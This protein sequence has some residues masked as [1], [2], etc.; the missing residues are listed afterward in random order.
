MNE[1]LC[2]S[3]SIPH[4][5]AF[6]AR[7][8]V[9]QNILVMQPRRLA[10]Q[11]LSK[12][13]SDLT[14]SAF[15]DIVGYR[16]SMESAVSQ[17]TRI[18]FATARFALQVLL[19]IFLTFFHIHYSRAVLFKIKYNLKLIDFKKASLLPSRPCCTQSQRRYRSILTSL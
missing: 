18:T 13:C 3:G 7:L 8:D 16:I 10:A 19:I 9:R 5:D 2:L 17:N 11:A 6:H 12:R 4:Y 15:G 1:I 14:D